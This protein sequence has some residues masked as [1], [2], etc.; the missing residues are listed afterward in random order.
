MVATP[1]G[2]GAC[3]VVAAID[4]PADDREGVARLLDQV[5]E[6]GAD[7]IKL[8]VRGG[9]PA[10]IDRVEACVT[11]AVGVDVI[12][13]PYDLRAHAEVTPLR[14]CAWKIDPPVMTHLPLL[15]AIGADGRPVMAAVAGCTGRELED[16]ASRL[17]GDATLI[18]TL[19]NVEDDAVDVIDVSYLTALRRYGR[20][21]GYADASVDPGGALVAVALGAA[22]VEKQLSWRHPARADRRGGLRPP[23]FRRFVDRV[24]RLEAVLS[25]DGTRDPLPEELDAVDEDRAS[26]VAAIPIPRGVPIRR[27]MLTLEPHASG[28]PP[29]FVEM[30]EG[31][32]ALYDLPAGALVTFGVIEP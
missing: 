23:E 4:V 27:E 20:P 10:H 8:C 19:L 3:R 29:R 16:A 9:S 22:V 30:M 26:I 24:R 32:C 17:P 2:A 13:A 21:V 12:L 5:R 15:D 7:A 14:F 18:H 28:L 25:S 6:C 1:A 11:A 31:R